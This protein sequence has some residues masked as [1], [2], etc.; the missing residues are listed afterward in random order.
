MNDRMNKRTVASQGRELWKE[1]HPVPDPF[2]GTMT[3][4]AVAIEGH[5]ALTPPPSG[6]T[7]TTPHMGGWTVAK[8]LRVTACI[9]SRSWESGRLPGLAGSHPRC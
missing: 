7:T 2:S 8:A 9:G 5:C 1:Q 4:L 3:P 6:S